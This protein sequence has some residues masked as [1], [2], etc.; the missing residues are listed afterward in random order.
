MIEEPRKRE[1]LRSV[2]TT[3]LRVVEGESLRDKTRT[4]KSFRNKPEDE[5]QKVSY[6]REIQFQEETC[7]ESCKFLPKENHFKRSSKE[8]RREDALAPGAEEGRDKL[9][10][11]TGRCK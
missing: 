4:A 6:K 8:E 9:R 2:S 1:L 10:K 5:S 3:T 7:G 11:A